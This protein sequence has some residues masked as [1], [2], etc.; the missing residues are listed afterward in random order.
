MHGQVGIAANRAREVAIVF[1]AERVV[2]DV[3]GRVLGLLQTAQQ[4]VIDGPLVRPAG[5]TLQQ[6]LQIAAALALFERIAQ[7]LG[8]LSQQLELGEIGLAVSASDEGDS[9]IVEG[10]RRPRCSPRA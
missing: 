8:E 9:P 10:R 6:V 3:R 2:P 5:D 7:N 1:D 4:G